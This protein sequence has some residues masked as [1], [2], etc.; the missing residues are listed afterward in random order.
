MKLKK[1]SRGAQLF[2]EG[3][4]AI[5]LCPACHQ[6][7][8]DM[9]G[10]PYG[11]CH[12]CSQ[13]VRLRPTAQVRDELKAMGLTFP[14][15][16]S[17]S[18]FAGQPVSP[19]PLIEGTR[20]TFDIRVFLDEP[21]ASLTEVFPDEWDHWQDVVMAN[22]FGGERGEYGDLKGESWV[23]DP[24]GAQEAEA[25]AAQWARQ[26]REWQRAGANEWLLLLRSRARKWPP[27]YR[28][29]R[30]KA[31]RQSLTL[32]RHPALF[33]ELLGLIQNAP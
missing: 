17:V 11:W 29:G 19:H 1:P 10:A 14:N 21:W 6:Y 33:A 16:S 27:L 5:G 28:Q 8:V 26:V 7:V 22:V 30:E 12:Q 31:L 15:F 25:M 24:L 23:M 13:E 32:H 2:A 3:A 18:P 9:S 20:A 4:G